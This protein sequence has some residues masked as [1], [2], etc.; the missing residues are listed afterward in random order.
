M[1]GPIILDTGPLGRIAHPR[2]NPD[3]T[4]W[5]EELPRSG[6]VVFLPEI[7][8]YELRRN[9]LLEGLTRSVARLDQL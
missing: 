7:A 3:I 4:S 6:A 8:D 9:L 2:R 1:V 5:L